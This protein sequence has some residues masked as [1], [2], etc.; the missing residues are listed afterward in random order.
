M[1]IAPITTRVRTIPVEVALGPADG[2][3]RACAVTPDTIS[4][5][6]KADLQEYIASLQTGKIAEVEAALRFALALPAGHR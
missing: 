3:P 1:T 6:P 4:T 5:I 2:L